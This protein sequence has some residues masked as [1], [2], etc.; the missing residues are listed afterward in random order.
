MLLTT[1]TTGQLGY[2]VARCARNRG[3]RAVHLVRS[4]DKVARDLELKQHLLVADLTKDYKLPP[5][6]THITHLAGCTEHANR[7]E[8]KRLHAAHVALANRASELK[9]LQRFTLAST[10]YPGDT[11]PYD[12][13]KRELEAELAKILGDKLLVL[14]YPPLMGTY[15]RGAAGHLDFLWV[16]QAA[17]RTGCF[18]LSPTARL[19]VAP[20]DV[21]AN[22]TLDLTYD[23]RQLQPVYDVCV[24]DQAPTWATVCERAGIQTEESEVPE[25]LLRDVLKLDDAGV[26]LYHRVRGVFKDQLADPL[27][28]D[29]RLLRELT[30]TRIP[31][32]ETYVVALV[33]ETDN[34]PFVDLLRSHAR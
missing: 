1:G 24:G 20:L 27:V 22:L 29:D 15:N 10:C 33:R 17:R 13:D 7:Q 4:P 5:A 21:V 32:L 19:D 8:L 12:Q 16:L 28:F 34:V 3:L 14:R 25:E 30:G 23:K 2:E 6:V 26:K 31:T 11:S 18:P 9:G